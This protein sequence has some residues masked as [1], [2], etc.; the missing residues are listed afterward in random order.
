MA[1]GA[2]VP[3]ASVKKMELLGMGEADAL[4]IT[5]GIVKE[6]TAQPSAAA[7]AMRRDLAATRGI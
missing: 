2:E 6:A 5:S 3:G 1:G 4:L 7:V